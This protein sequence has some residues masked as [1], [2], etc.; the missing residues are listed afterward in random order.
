VRTLTLPLYAAPLVV[1]A[2]VALDRFL[3]AA[4]TR[5]QVVE[6]LAAVP[7]L[8]G[9]VP[10]GRSER[11]ATRAEALG[12]GLDRRQR[13]QVGTVARLVHVH[14]SVVEAAG[15]DVEVVRLLEE[16]RGAPPERVGP[17]A[18]A[19]RVA[20]TFEAHVEAVPTSGALFATLVAH[21][22]GEE[23]RA[24]EALVRFVQQR[25]TWV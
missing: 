5:R 7:E 19:V 12:R 1:A 25:P 8:A 16:V 17:A 2:A 22:R 20:A 10:A 4:R 24:A 9:S 15:A 21:Q 23:R 6:A 18:A 3:R 11:V 13:A 14:S